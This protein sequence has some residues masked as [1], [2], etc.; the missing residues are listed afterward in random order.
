[1]RFFKFHKNRNKGISSVVGGLFFL[2]LMTAGFSVYYVALDNQSKM[3]VAQQVIADTEIKKIREKFTISVSTDPND[4]NRLAIQ[5][6]NQGFNTV[7]IADAWIINKTTTNQPAKKHEVKYNDAFIPTQFSGDIFAN[8]PL[9][10]SPGEYDIKVISTL[11]TIVTEEKFDPNNTGFGGNGEEVVL[12]DELFGKPGTFVVFPNPLDSGSSNVAVWGVNVIN[13]TDQPLY[14]SKV[15]IM[16]VSPR[17]TSSDKIFKDNCITPPP[18]AI[19]PTTNKWSCP[20]SNQLMWR[21]VLNPQEISPRSVFPFLAIAT[22]ENVGGSLNDA[23][24]VLV[25]PVV[26]TTL[27]QFGKAGYATSMHSKFVAVP[28]V[29]LAKD[30]DSMASAD[31]MSELR[32]ITAGSSVVFNATLADFDTLNGHQINAG[33][34]LII[35]VPKGWS[36]PIILSNNGFDPPLVQPFPDGSSQIIGDLTLGLDGA[37]KTIQFSS[38]APTITTTK[39][40]V[41]YILADGTASGENGPAEG[42]TVGPLAETVLQVCPTTGCP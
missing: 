1:M 3:V 27:G 12:K 22:T 41:M 6:K 7:E 17:A 8:T 39:M 15:V 25:Q 21:D 29:F 14:V 42:F 36:T 31:I 40:Y 5:V 11:G 9:Y 37:A 38:T 4:N 2:V 13:P 23:M 30:K 19:P 20:E 26:F 35:N 16:A 28:N 33:S 10:M 18:V 32:G 24:N 34:R